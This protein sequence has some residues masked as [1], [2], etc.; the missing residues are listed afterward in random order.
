MKDTGDLHARVRHD[1]KAQIINL[2]AF[3]GEVERALKDFEH[4]NASDPGCAKLPESV[5]DLIAQDLRPCLSLISLAT[6][7]LDH[8]LDDIL[9]DNSGTVGAPGAGGD[10]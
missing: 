5:N 9:R 8:V 2:R 1:C 7:R 3:C 10:L 4:Q 6:D